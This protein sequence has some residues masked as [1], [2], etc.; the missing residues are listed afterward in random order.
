MLYYKTSSEKEL[1]AEFWE[2]TW[3]NYYLNVCR[4]T[5]FVR[6]RDFGKAVKMEKIGQIRNR[7]RENEKTGKRDR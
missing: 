5:I 1:G 2:K 4:N 7:K 3:F 6:R